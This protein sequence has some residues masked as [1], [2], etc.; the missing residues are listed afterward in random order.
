MLKEHL[1][2]AHDDA[3]RRF[4]TIDK[5]VSWIQEHI[6]TGSPTQS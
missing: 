3:S 6:L 1:S 2:K 5:H 4:E